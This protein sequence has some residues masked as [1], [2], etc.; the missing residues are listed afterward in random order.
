MEAHNINPD[1]HRILS[2][3]DWN[4]I[5]DEMSIMGNRLIFPSSGLILCGF[6]INYINQ[7]SAIKIPQII[8]DQGTDCIKQLFETNTSV[9]SELSDSEK[10][11]EIQLHKEFL[12]IWRHHMTDA[13]EEADL[14]IE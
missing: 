7:I 11:A 8:I 4:N 9:S 14:L 12:D 6:A 13:L 1:L 10:A 5:A 3:I 2:T